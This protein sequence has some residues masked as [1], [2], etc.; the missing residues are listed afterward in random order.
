MTALDPPDGD[1]ACLTIASRR[2]MLSALAIAPLAIS[3]GTE[4]SLWRG[5][6]GQQA[7][8][9]LAP[10]QRSREG[11]R[12]SRFRYHNAESFFRGVE[13]HGVRHSTDQLYQVGI[14]LQLGLCSH[15]LDVGFEDSWCARHIGLNLTRSLTYANA[16]GLDFDTPA[17]ALLAAILSPYGKW[18]HA[19]LCYVPPDLPF[20]PYEIWALTRALLDQVHAVTGHP[21]PRGWR[22]PSRTG[23]A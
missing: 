12:L 11:R 7:L 5:T 1:N 19:G 21:R 18:R 3:R 9:E 23:G 16:T 6:V 15:L 8:D 2:T 20:P 4:A 13:R 22:Q 10:L 17:F 14:V